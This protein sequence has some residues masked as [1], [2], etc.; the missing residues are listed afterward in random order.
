MSLLFDSYSKRQL[1]MQIV[2]L[3]TISLVYLIHNLT[4]TPGPPP[5]TRHKPTPAATSHRHRP[6]LTVLL[7]ITQ[8]GLCLFHINHHLHRPAVPYITLNGT[9]RILSS[10]RSTTGQIVVADDLERGFRFL[11]ADA[12]IL[13]GRWCKDPVDVVRQQESPAMGDSYVT[14]NQAYLVLKEL[15]GGL[16]GHGGSRAGCDGA[17]EQDLCDFSFARDWSL[18]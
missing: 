6:Y 13:G 2:L 15:R 4:H 7:C 18:G 9:L 16:V 5:S 10:Q 3:S 11:R 17:D 12:S 14:S 8:L 1:T